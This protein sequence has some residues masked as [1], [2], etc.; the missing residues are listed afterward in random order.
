MLL[1]ASFLYISAVFAFGDSTVDTGNN[2]NRKTPF[3]AN[4]W[5]YGYDFPGHV[6]SG[7]CSNG[8]LIP[9]FEV[10]LLGIKDLLPAYLDPMVTD[11]DL[12]TGVSFASAGCGLDTLMDHVYNVINMS[13]QLD[14]FNECLDRIRRIAGSSVATNIVEN[15]LI[16]ISAG[17]VDM[18]L[19]TMMYLL[20]VFDIQF[21]LIK[22]SSLETFNP[23]FKTHIFI[24]CFP[25]IR[26]R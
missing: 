8:K 21:Q 7:R 3:K 6:P 15:S 22:I 26:N 16:I 23:L 12:I 25:F 19:L 1:H 20:G 24:P 9:D 13:T 2:N 17:S 10:S 4:H 14:Y 11:K 18:C 5:P